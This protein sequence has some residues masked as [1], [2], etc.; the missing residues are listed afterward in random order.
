MRKCALLLMGVVLY[1]SS[2]SSAQMS[3]KKGD[4]DGKVRRLLSKMTLEE[5]VGQM[6][7]VTLEVVAGKS[8]DSHLSLDEQKLRDAIVKHY[9]GSILNCGGQARTAE[10]WREIITKIQDIATKDTRLGIPVIYGIDAIHGAN[11]TL[12]A[13]IFPQN[14]AMAATGNAELMQ[15]VGEITAYEVRAS[16]MP[17]NF[18]PVLDLARQPFW[19][20]FFETFGEDPY[21][22]SVM[23]A[24][25]IKGLQGDDISNPVKVAACMK[26]YLGYGFPY[27]GKD[28]TPAYIP[29]R[30]LRQLF[31]KPFAA[32]VKAGVSTVMVNSSEINGIPVHASRYLLTDVLRGELDFKGFVVSDWADIE[33]L[34]TREMVAKDRREAVKIAVMA[35][36]DMSMVPYDYSFFETVVDLVKSGEVPVR[37][38]DQAVADILRV[39]FQLGLFDSPYPNKTLAGGFASEASRKINL[40]AA[41]EAVTL[42]KNENRTLPLSRDKKVL[43]TGPCANKLSCLNSGWTITWQGDDEKLYPQEK[44]TILEAI[45]D[46]LG[47]DNVKYVEAV[48]FDKELDVPQAVAAARDAD[49]VIA[50]V[51]EPAYCETP[52]NIDD[53]TMSQPQLRLIEELAGTGKPVV[54]VLVEGRPRV[55]RG[56]VDRTQAILM[57]YLP[58]MEG[59]EAVADILFGDVNPSGKLPFTYPKYSYGHVC[60]DHK[61]SEEKAPNKFDPQWQFGRGLSYTTF[62]YGKL[63]LD[64]NELSP[65]DSLTVTVEVAN[66]G[67]RAGKETVQLF[68]S[69]LVASVTPPVRS[70]NR[71]S[72]VE[73]QPG[74]SETVRFIL[75]WDDFS[76]IG[77]DNKPVVEPGEFRVI[78]GDLSQTFVIR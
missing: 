35:G 1:C 24:A 28:R 13:T 16:G 50:C 71:F 5:K 14:I 43:V 15:K 11:Y 51:G 9:V 31:L 69:D 40:Q 8:Q 22:A 20:R 7:Q 32:A 17:W 60:Y 70:L 47:K 45:Q 63:R 77:Q 65:K 76:F 67:E 36:I 29:D 55:I 12:G 6:T 37:R 2:W 68:L 39:K 75:G 27:S 10:N 19:P 73:L 54:V 74:K 42:L 62:A 59:G 44:M 21:V 64:K 78:V 58:G 56:I 34:Y 61:P 3:G 33:N 46:K 66:T 18:N 25:Y 4:I 26:H 48:T 38:I 52:G 72:K 30:Q 41:H 49:A 53:L 57:A 23:G